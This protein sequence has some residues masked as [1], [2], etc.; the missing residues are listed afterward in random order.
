MSPN[1]KKR[2]DGG[3]EEL[4]LTDNTQDLGRT[5]NGARSVIERYNDIADA[6]VLADPNQTPL[7]DTNGYMFEPAS[8]GMEMDEMEHDVGR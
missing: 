7:P 8:E 4:G 1:K 3:G 2:H 6:A 5:I